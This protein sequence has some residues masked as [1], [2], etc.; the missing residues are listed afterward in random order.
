[1]KLAIGIPNTGIIKAQTAFALIRT[2]KSFPHNYDILFKEGS[3]LHHNRE[4]LVKVA[5]ELKCTHL[6]F[7]DS[8][9]YFE[10]DAILRL[11]KRKKDIIGAN[12]YRRTLPLIDTVIAPKKKGL[13]TCDSIGTGFM[14]INLNV[15]KKLSEPWF[16]WETNSNGD[17]VM[18]EDFWF[19]RKARKAGYKI[20]CD[21]T[22]PIR[23]IGD[24]YY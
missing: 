2:L 9:M 16:F 22:I 14:L 10:K 4:T 20:W 6:L 11:I 12:Y 5:I 13:T 3:I 7:L 1:M 18:S 21:L 15:F 8:D 24:Y 19:C 23:H 17:M